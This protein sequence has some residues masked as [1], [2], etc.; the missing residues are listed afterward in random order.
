LKHVLRFPGIYSG[1]EKYLISVDII[2]ARGLLGLSP[3]G[4]YFGGLIVGGWIVT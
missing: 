2:D 1:Y 4:G 3:L